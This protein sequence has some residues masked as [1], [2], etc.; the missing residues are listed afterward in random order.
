MPGDHG[1]SL[2]AYVANDDDQP[3]ALTCGHVLFGEVGELVEQPAYEDDEE[4]VPDIDASPLQ[5]AIAASHSLA[6]MSAHRLD[7][8][9]LSRMKSLLSSVD[10]DDAAIQAA[11]SHGLSA[12]L[13]DRRTE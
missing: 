8:Y 13:T 6:C 5:S 3:Q 11:I 1:G 7:P 2:G 9:D 10:T 12:P 4:G